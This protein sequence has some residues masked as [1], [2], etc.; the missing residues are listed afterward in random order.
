MLMSERK[1]PEAT[2]GGAVYNVTLWRDV[3]TE[4]RGIPVGSLAVERFWLPILGSTSVAMIRF[5]CHEV[6]ELGN[7]GESFSISHIELTAR[8]GLGWREVNP[9]SPVKNTKLATTVTRCVDFRAMK[10]AGLDWAVRSVLPVPSPR[11]IE[12]WHP[13]IQAEFARW[14]HGRGQS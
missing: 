3:A 7:R 5:L 11:Q 9:E 6:V 12:R 13:K 10:V 2:V 1:L 4:Q 14:Q 8:L